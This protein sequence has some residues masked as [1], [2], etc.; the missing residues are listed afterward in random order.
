MSQCAEWKLRESV[1]MYKVC[2]LDDRNC[3]D[4]FPLFSSPVSGGGGRVSDQ[5]EETGRG[6]RGGS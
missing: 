6:A 5:E 1:G 3:I 4:T 2:C